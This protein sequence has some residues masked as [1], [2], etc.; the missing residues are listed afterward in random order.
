M[1]NGVAELTA[2]RSPRLS[3]ARPFG[4]FKVVLPPTLVGEIVIFGTGFA[5]APPPSCVDRNSTIVNGV[6]ALLD[7]RLPN[8]SKTSAHGAWIEPAPSSF[9]T[10]WGAIVCVP[11]SPTS[12]A[13]AKPSIEVPALFATHRLPVSG[14]NAIPSGP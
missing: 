9:K 14:E 11:V 7:H 2:E 8:E 1:P 4:A 5:P 10:S 13:A 6:F 3:K 12:E